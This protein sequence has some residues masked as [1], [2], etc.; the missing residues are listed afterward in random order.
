V[1]LAQTRPVPRRGRARGA[2]PDPHRSRRAGHLGSSDVDL[3]THIADVVN[4]LVYRDLTDVVLVGNSSAGM[5]ITGVAEE[6]PDRIAE[7]VYLDAFV[8]SDG[9]CLRD[10]I[11][12]ERR[13]GM[14]NLV[15]SEGDGW[16]LP[17][18]ASPL[19]E[20]FLPQTW[21]I[22]DPDDLA[23]MLER[24]RPTPIGHF[25]KPVSVTN[26]QARALPRSYVRFTRW[27]HPGFDRWAQAAETAPGWR[28]RRLDAA[29]LAYITSPAELSEVLLE[30]LAPAAAAPS[31]A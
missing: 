16:L 31:S 11:P 19:W 18:F 20:Q 1:E 2:H 24:L 3:G 22:T 6:V 17:R 12:P 15:R 23:W 29:H 8:P 27:P 10:M 21:E 30:L 5:V 4:T 13:A 7:L 28:L 25:A 26:P 9:Q 14:E